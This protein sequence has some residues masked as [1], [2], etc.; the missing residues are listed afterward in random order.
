M[1][2]LEERRAVQAAARGQSGVVSA[3][4]AASAAGELPGVHGR[5]GGLGSIDDKYDVAISTAC[6]SLDNIVVDDTDAA[7]KCVE[8]LRARKL[9]VATFIMLDKVAA[10]KGEASKRHFEAPAGSQ[11][12]FDLV[13]PADAKY[14]PAFYHAPS[15]SPSPISC[16]YA[17]A[18]YHALNDTLVCD[19]LESV[20]Y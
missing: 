1:G 9:G 16:R 11:R 17:P 15:P 6:G 12:L 7:Q 3:L 20:Q 2:A 4:L 14:A 19:S 10:N 13:K 8:L 18:F 5:L